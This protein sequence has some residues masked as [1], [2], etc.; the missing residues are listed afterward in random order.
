MLKSLK[1]ILVNKKPLLVAFYPRFT[2]F[3]SQIS[4]FRFQYS[5]IL[6]Y[7]SIQ[8][9]CVMLC[10]SKIFVDKY[11]TYVYYWKSVF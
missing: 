4:K 11:F 2:F 5:H 3:L 7:F 10:F 9:L 8:Y 1:S 6:T